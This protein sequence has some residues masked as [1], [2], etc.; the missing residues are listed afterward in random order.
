MNRIILLLFSLLVSGISFSTH[1]RAGEITYEHKFGHT[2]E[3]TIRI[4]SN[5]G[6]NIADRPELEIFWGDGS[7]DTLARLSEIPQPSIG[8]FN[9]SENIYK[10][11]HTYPGPGTYKIEVLDPNRNTGILNIQNSV[12]VAF[13]VRTTLIIDAFNVGNNSCQPQEFPCPEIGCVGVPYCYNAAAYDPDGDSLSYSLVPC[14]EGNQNDNGCDILALGVVYDYP[15]TVGGGTISIDPENGTVCWDSPQIQGE[16]NF[17]VAI[18]EWQYG[19]QRGIVIRDIQVTILGNCSNDPPSITDIDDTCVVA[20]ASLSGTVTA[21]DPN[22]DNV[23]IEA[24]GQPFDETISPATFSQPS[25]ATPTTGTFN[26][27][28]DCSH[29]RNWPYQVIFIAED[30]DPVVPLID[31]SSFNIN[32]NPPPV[33]GLTVNPLGNSMN[34][35]WDTCSCDNIKGYK[36]YRKLG[37][38]GATPS[39]C[40]DANTA[41]AMGYTLVGTN[42]GHTNTTFTDNSGLIL[43]QQYCYVVVVYMTDGAVSCPSSEVCDELNLDFPV[44]INVSVGE[45]DLVNGI[46]TVRW[47]HPTELDTNSQFPGPYQYKIY[48]YNGFGIPATLIFTTPSEDSLWEV[49]DELIVTS[50]LSNPMNTDAIPHT[51]K[52]ELWYTHPQQGLQP[53]GSTSNASSVFVTL[54]PSDNAIDVTWQ[55]NVPWTNTLYEVYKETFAGS[56]IFNLLGTTTANNY[57]DTGLINGVTYC[58]KVK[59]IGSYSSPQIPSPLVNWSEEECEEPVDMTPPCAPELTLDSDCFIPINILTWNNPNNSCADDVMSY[60][61]YFTPVEGEPFQLLMT[62]SL[63]TDTTITH[64]VLPDTSIAGCYYVTAVDSVQYGNESEPS[65]IVC[66]DNCPNYSL[67]NVFS[68][69]GDGF[70]DLFIPFPYRYIESIELR[71]YNRWGQVIFESTDPDIL[72]N[73]KSMENNQDVPEGVYYYYCKVNTIRLAG[74]DPVELTGFFHLFRDGGSGGN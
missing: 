13:C 19:V 24:T 74:I 61:L 52:A 42:I 43:G 7:R 21:T 8:S 72:W 64:L 44:M 70:N 41:T 68:P 14:M 11:T 29:I 59:S 26:W 62:F 30:N 2:Y 50:A 35:S 10:G 23:V 32:V 27:N 55:C 25:T 58:Y 60:N 71:I 15:H 67:P 49:Q 9:G 48:Q 34:L 28:T 1:N 73:G 4:C 51:Y 69:N 17:A 18:T 6:A 47:F 5:E 53:V 57:L 33:T 38:G 63:N 46:D 37:S 22:G 40:C 12:N 56:G 65:N 20:G 36:I 54:V 39:G 66:A 45:T 16:Y 3:V 31:V